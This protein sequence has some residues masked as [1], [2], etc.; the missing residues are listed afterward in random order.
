MME[1]KVFKMQ[2]AG[3]VTAWRC[4]GILCSVCPQLKPIKDISLM[5]STAA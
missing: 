2:V 3:N 4:G 5:V 1:L